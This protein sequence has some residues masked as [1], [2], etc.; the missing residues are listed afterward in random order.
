MISYSFPPIGGS[1]VHRTLRFIK[2]LPEFGW[3]PTVVTTTNN[4]HNNIDVSLLSYIP[5]KTGVIRIPGFELLNYYNRYTA[6]H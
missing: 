3:I 6:P 5:Q 1:G 2:Y 4:M